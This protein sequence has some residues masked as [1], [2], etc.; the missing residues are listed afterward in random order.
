MAFS[1]DTMADWTVKGEGA[2][3]CPE[4]VDAKRSNSAKLYSSISWVQGFITG[5]NY[6]RSLSKD[7]NSAIAQ[8]LAP[9]SMVLWIDDYCREN[10]V[11]D[12]ADAAA[13]LVK[14][15]IEKE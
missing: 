15:L 2:F 14:G 1:I 7:S 5:V 9:T 13:A 8:D 3:S 4:Y 11:D 12:L 10:L 6:Q